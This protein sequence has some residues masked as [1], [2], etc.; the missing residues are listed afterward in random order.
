MRGLPGGDEAAREMFSHLT[1]GRGGVDV[2]PPAY[3]PSGRM[4]EL[5]DGSRIGYGPD[6]KTGTPTVDIEVPGLWD[7]IRRVQFD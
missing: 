4:I 5:P 6:S 2:T 7:I 3:P 1:T